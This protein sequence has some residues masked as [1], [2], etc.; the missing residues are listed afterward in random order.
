MTV[1]GTGPQIE[2]F[3]DRI[4]IVNPGKPL[5]KA[6]R[7]IDLPARSRNESLAALMRRMGFCEEQGSGL[8]KVID[9]V[10]F[11]QLPPPLFR[12]NDDS[13]HVILYGPRTFA[14]MTQD[15]RVRACYQHAILRWLSGDR[16]KNAT[17]CKRL[18]IEKRNASQATKVITKAQKE[19]FI[20]PADIEHPRSGYVPCWA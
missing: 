15:E 12:E 6:D 13:M 18:G 4:E 8:D 2:L 1:T 9:E 5:V 14:R 16:M 7:M 10:E 20:K 3:E 19:G 11:F 17:L